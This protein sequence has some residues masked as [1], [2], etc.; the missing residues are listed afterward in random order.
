MD[1]TTTNLTPT[2]GGHKL[3]P[4]V[5][6]KLGYD[7]KI[8]VYGHHGKCYVEVW[9][10]WLGRKGKC[11]GSGPFDDIQSAYISGC[12]SS[13]CMIDPP[14]SWVE[15]WVEAVRQNDSDEV[16]RGRQVPKIGGKM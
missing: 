7:V 16:L 10:N 13:H 3:R 11:A 12:K 14:A 8:A 15:A 2:D 9:A 4:M 5:L 1:D 6:P